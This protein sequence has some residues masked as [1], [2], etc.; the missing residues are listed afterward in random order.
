[1]ILPC[2]L[3]ELQS[4]SVDITALINSFMMEV[5]TQSTFTCSM[6]TIETSEQGLKYVQ[7]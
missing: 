1:M 2:M 5:L 3:F 4:A 6:L 7:S